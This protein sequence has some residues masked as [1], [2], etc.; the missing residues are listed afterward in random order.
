V[1]LKGANLGTGKS[2]SYSITTKSSYC[3]PNGACSAGCRFALLRH[4]AGISSCNVVS[5]PPFV[6][7]THSNITFKVPAGVGSVVNFVV[8]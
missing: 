4:P 6:K 7:H 1:V 3:G 5:R 8:K 2:N